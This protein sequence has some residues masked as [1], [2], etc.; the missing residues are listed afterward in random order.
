M[1]AYNAES[2]VDKAIE[3]VI[4]QIYADWELIII[5]DCSTDRTANI[6]EEYSKKDKRIKL[7]KS[8][9]NNGISRTK[10]AALSKA[11]GKYIAFCDDDD[12]MDR[13]ALSEN[14]RL[15]EEHGSQVV[16]WSY[17]T[18]RINEEGNITKIV[19]IKCKDGV[20]GDRGTIFDNYE[21][22]HTML[23][24][25]WTGLYDASLLYKHSIRFDE[26]FEYGGEDTDFNTNILEHVEKMLM[27]S[28]CYYDW[29]V[30]K[31]HSTTE[32]R[33]INFCRSMIKVAQ[34]EYKLIME[35]CLNNKCIW[36]EYRSFYSDLIQKYARN[37]SDDEKDEI[38]RALL[39]AEWCNK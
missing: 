8:D 25:D 17:R 23:S 27:N 34:R 32:K 35:N 20:Y 28:N 21:N 29:Y 26:S 37:L 15:M 38:G 6:C 36:N 3:S 24:C 13:R 19:E 5:D 16:R 9:K 31:K 14:V 2:Y 7:F 10:N 30:R 1:P 18:I 11:N 4:R 12:I 39:S 33:N 22:V